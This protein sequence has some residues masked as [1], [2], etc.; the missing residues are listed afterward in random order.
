[1]RV[2]RYT[3][4]SKPEIPSRDITWK[5]DLFVA[6]IA[7]T[8]GWRYHSLAVS[9]LGL[10]HFELS[11]PTGLPAHIGW[12]FMRWGIRARVSLGIYVS[13]SLGV[14]EFQISCWKL[15][16]LIRKASPDQIKRLREILLDGD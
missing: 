12:Y 9:A 15:R 13:L 1:M 6:S 3:D 10:L 2:W 11:N 4:K 16:R 8:G 14:S 7:Y 5:L